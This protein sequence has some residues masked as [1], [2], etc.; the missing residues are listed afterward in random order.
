MKGSCYYPDFLVYRFTTWSKDGTKTFTEWYS[1]TPRNRPDVYFNCFLSNCP[2]FVKIN[3]CMCVLK[4]FLYSKF[5]RG[6]TNSKYIVK[7]DVFAY[8]KTPEIPD[9]L[10]LR[11]S[12]FLPL[13]VTYFQR[14][15]K[16]IFRESTVFNRVSSREGLC[17]LK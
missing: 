10:C 13:Y 4:V 8:P 14:N 6:S 7:L 2:L 17:L 9:Y 12:H 3:V 1:G 15:N 11:P 16:S 5:L